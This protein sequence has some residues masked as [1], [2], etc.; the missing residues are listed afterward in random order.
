MASLTSD[1]PEST[2]ITA[3]TP[4]S[5]L[6]AVVS[7]LRVL[8]DC[9]A[10]RDWS[11]ALLEEPAPDSF[12]AQ[13][14]PLRGRKHAEIRLSAYFSAFPPETQRHCLV[15]ELLHCHLAPCGFVAQDSLEPSIAS[16]FVVSLE[17]GVDG[18]ADAIAPLMPLPQLFV[19]K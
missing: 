14:Q 16:A 4:V 11:F 6:C 9:L 15:H 12:A 7:Y 1:A 13:I 2:G 18:L 19:V 5:S 8:A 10:L 3:E 17:Y